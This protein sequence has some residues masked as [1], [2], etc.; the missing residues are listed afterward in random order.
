MN[1]KGKKMYTEAIRLDSI[2]LY[3]SRQSYDFFGVC[4]DIGGIIEVFYVIAA[5][6]VSPFAAVSFN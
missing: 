5:L 2:S 3:T 6:L 4:S 1:E